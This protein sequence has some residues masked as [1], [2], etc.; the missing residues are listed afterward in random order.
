MARLTDAPGVPGTL[1]MLGRGRLTTANTA[2]MRAITATTPSVIV[3]K[4]ELPIIDVVKVVVSVTVEFV[5]FPLTSVVVEIDVV[6]SVIV[7]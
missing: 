5:T 7:V 1:G 6:V 2:M 3:V 4:S